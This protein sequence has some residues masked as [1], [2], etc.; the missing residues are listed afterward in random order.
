MF[1]ELLRQDKVA[2]GLLQPASAISEA[3]SPAVKNLRELNWAKF[4]VEPA[5]I[6]AVLLTHAHLDHSGY[7]PKLVR[8]GYRGPIFGTSATMDVAGLKLQ[9]A[10]VSLI[11]TSSTRTAHL[12]AELTVLSHE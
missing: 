11:R 1:D 6:D 5:S 2:S 9:T 10:L 12:R 3:D 7:L 4:P 8:D